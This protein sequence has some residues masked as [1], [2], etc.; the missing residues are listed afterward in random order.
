LITSLH[1]AQVVRARKLKKRGMRERARRFLVEG[2]MGITEALASGPGLD[3]LF[4]ESGPGGAA[5]G[6]LFEAARRRATPCFEVSPQVMRVISGATTPPGAVAIAPFVDAEPS[7]LLG[8]PGTLVVVVDQVRDPGNLGTILRTA[9]AAGVGSLFL[10]EGT[11]DVY[12]PK[13]VRAAAGAFFHL[14]FARE[15][16]M[17]SVLRELGDRGLRRI[18]AAPGARVPYDELDLTGPCALVFGNEIRGLEE[19]AAAS[20]DELAFIPMAG[21]ADSLN[22]GVA[23][24]VFLFEAQRQ[25]RR[26]GVRGGRLESPDPP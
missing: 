20:V 13:V 26:R 5:A 14:R 19:E 2:A 15:L 24:A 16:T 1:N 6:E 3:A 17:G 23:A 7:R 18:G 22:V 11:V 9:W 12:N 8:D 25:R 10:G 4:V 21:S